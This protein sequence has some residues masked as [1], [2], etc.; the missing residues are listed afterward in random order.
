MRKLRALWFHHFNRAFVN[1][2]MIHRLSVLTVS[3]DAVISLLF[4]A[5]GATSLRTKLDHSPVEAS[6]PP[7]DDLVF[8]QLLE[9]RVSV[10]FG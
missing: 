7:L 9:K 5:K 3:P 1:E 4:E 2:P 6:P 10:L 8:F